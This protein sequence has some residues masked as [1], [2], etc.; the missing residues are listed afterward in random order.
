MPKSLRK[1]ILRKLFHLMEL[2]ALVVYSI[3]R[4]VWSDKAAGLAL[5]ALF[6]LLMEIE[7]VRLEVK[8][9]FPEAIDVF[10]PREKDNVTGA[11]FF[12]A[13]TIICFSVF[14]YTIAFTALL[15]TI[16]GDLA[17]ALIGIK[18]GK[19]KLFRKKSLEGFLAGLAMNLIVGALIMPDYPAIYLTMAFVAS[20]VELL[21]GKLDDNLTVPLFAGF[22]GQLIAYEMQVNLTSLS[23]PLALIFKSIGF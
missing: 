14:D 2:P 21:T 7:Y 19:H 17:S 16:F 18:F 10:R 11:I 12:V 1:E 13:A 4:H 22:T 9:K 20:T 6:L 3:I 5:T 15:L 23:G 8:P